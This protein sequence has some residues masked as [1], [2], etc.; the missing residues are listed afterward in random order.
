[1]LPGPEVSR[2]EPVLERETKELGDV[3][4]IEPPHQVEAM[5]FDGADADS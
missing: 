3:T 4:N 1:M 2:Q 5:H